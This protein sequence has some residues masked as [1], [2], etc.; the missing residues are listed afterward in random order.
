MG[1]EKTQSHI[2]VCYPTHTK[3]RKREREREREREIVV[4]VVTVIVCCCRR[5]FFSDV[6]AKPGESVLN[7]SS[8][9][10]KIGNVQE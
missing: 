2:V 4:V 7:H 8:N 1:R 10:E 5:G 6:L 3:D 9:V